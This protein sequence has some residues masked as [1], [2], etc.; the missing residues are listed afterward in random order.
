MNDYQRVADAVARDIRSGRLRPGDRLPP[1][2]AFARQRRIAPSTAARVYAELA[3]RGLTVGEVGRGTFVRAGADAA[4]GV[5]ALSEPV[6]RGH[7][8]LELN[9]P[10]L[11]GRA[12]ALAAGL[13]GLLRPDV[14]AAA[15]APSGVAGTAAAR[16][17][18]GA[19]LARG[20]WRPAADDVL[21]TGNGRQ[22]IAAA[23]A[24]LVPPGGRLG[25]ERLT[26]P[27]LAA[28]AARAGVR[29][30]PLAM[31]GDGLLPE[32]V[33]EAH[34][35]APLHAVYVQPVLHNPLSVTMPEA[36]ARALADVLRRTGLPAVEDGIWSFLRDDVPPLAAYAP[37]RVVLIDS[38]SKRIAP[39]LP[40]GFAVVPPGL[41]DGVARAVRAGGAAPGRFVLEA[42]ARW[43]ADGTA[44]DLAA[45]KRRDAAARQEILAGALG[46]FALRT[47]PCS[48]FCW[49]DLPP[50][51][52]ADTFVV[53]AARRGVS[54]TPAAAFAVGDAGTPAA[55]RV[56]LAAPPPEVL[57]RSL[58]VLA[59]V[60][61]S[62][63]R[64]E[65]SDD[66]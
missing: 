22:A 42:V 1:Q 59:G 53:A 51:W 55:V 33:E 6:A 49:W 56:A 45:A 58:R 11:P 50:A 40:L 54:V 32:A 16:D 7:V 47:D 2:R 12:A 20:G 61:R 25:T 13:G 66:R 44:R 35:A 28:L 21:F 38:L 8:D 24:A 29:L 30:V 37:D 31:D 65:A 63:P 17:A 27:V 43:V 15:L 41:R 14:L 19:L 23:V 4:P 34:R 64:D 5:P 39:G 60:A 10:L 3:R 9:H 52:R 46:G 48:Y 57:E 26:Y 18:A 62:D 36:R